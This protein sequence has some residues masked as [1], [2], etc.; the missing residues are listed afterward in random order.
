MPDPGF[1][2][3]REEEEV[4]GALAMTK[5]DVVGTEMAAAGWEDEDNETR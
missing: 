4:A 2:F 1:V 5:E 3:K